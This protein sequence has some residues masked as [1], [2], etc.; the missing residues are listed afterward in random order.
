[1]LTALLA[2]AAVQASS[3][4][5]AL[6]DY[7]A[8]VTGRFSSAAQHQRDR[9]YDEVEAR[10]VRIWPD[11]TDGLW[12]YQEQAIVNAPGLSREQALARP[13]F[14]FVARV[15]PLG[16]GSFRRD[17]YRVREPARF[18][19]ANVAALRHAD[20][21]EASCHN[22]IDRVG[23]GWYLGRTESCANRYRGAVFMES[24]SVSTPATYVNWD[25]GFDAQ[26]RRIWGPEA[27][28]YIFD[29][30]GESGHQANQPST[31]R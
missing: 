5:P 18:V 10:I 28:G 3:L 16:D 9:A 31:S 8:T 30:V 7:A 23:A 20:L 25:R 24:L 14:Q 12:L 2:F 15:V 11:R 22:R 29:R 27:G 19:G 13:Y 21:M 6:T 4:D 26:R 1:M 17:N